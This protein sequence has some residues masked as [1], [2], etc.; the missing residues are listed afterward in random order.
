VLRLPEEGYTYSQQLGLE[1]VKSQYGAVVIG[2]LIFPV[3]GITIAALLA[4]I[5]A[6]LFPEIST[7]AKAALEALSPLQWLII[8]VNP[9]AAALYLGKEFGEEVGKK[10]LDLNLGNQLRKALGL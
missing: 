10:V 5:L 8:V 2:A 6:M 9:G 7:G 3:F 1:F 4:P